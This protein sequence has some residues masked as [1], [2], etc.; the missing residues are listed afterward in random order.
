VR[1]FLI[2]DNTDTITGMRL[3]GI[4][5]ILVHKEEEIKHALEEI[6][7]DK[8]IAVV[9]IT[10]RLVDLCRNF[11]YELKLS[12]KKPLIVEIPDRHRSSLA[13]DSITNYVR[14]AIGLKI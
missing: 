1:F 13:K 4:P 9:L 11:V 7:N 12:Q 3:A 14:D 8:R 10:E 5:G 6:K 2:S